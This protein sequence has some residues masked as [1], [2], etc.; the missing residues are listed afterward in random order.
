MKSKDWRM[1]KNGITTEGEEDLTVRLH[2]TNGNDYFLGDASN[3]PKVDTPDIYK[4]HAG[5]DVIYGLG[6]QD[7]LFGGAGTDSVY[8]GYGADRIVGGLGNDTLS[9]DEQ[10]DTIM[11]GGG[12]DVFYFDAWTEESGGSGLDVITDFDVHERGE[13]VSMGIARGFEIATFAELKATMV[14]DGHDVVMG[15]G[16][17]ATL[18]LEDVRIAQLRADHFHIYVA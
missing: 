6:D 7:H 14:Q 12:A 4:G 10:E 8:G 18:V 3:A 16:G 13:H 15:F 11:G 1:K 5:N 2:G 17:I 9:G